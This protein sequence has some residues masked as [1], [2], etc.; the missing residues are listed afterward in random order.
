MDLNTYM[1]VSFSFWS[2]H[3][4][5]LFPLCSRP[6]HPGVGSAVWESQQGTCFICCFSDPISLAFKASLVVLSLFRSRE[7]LLPVLFK[8]NSRTNGNSV[9]S[10]IT[11][12]TCTAFCCCTA[13]HHKEVRILQLFLLRN[14]RAWKKKI[15][16]QGRFFPWKTPLGD[17]FPNLGVESTRTAAGRLTH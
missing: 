16:I 7:C 4:P 13:R 10:L 14:S 9:A 11:W 3:F 6:I 8:L 1:K 2:V 17:I 5:V 15:S 12:V